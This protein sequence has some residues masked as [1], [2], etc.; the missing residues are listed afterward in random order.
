MASVNG[1]ISWVGVN[2][3]NYLRLLLTW[4]LLVRVLVEVFIGLVVDR[5]TELNSIIL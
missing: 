4:F 1:D 2:Y 5:R 3:S